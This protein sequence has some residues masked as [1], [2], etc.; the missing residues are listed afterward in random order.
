MEEFKKYVRTNIAEMMEWTPSTTMYRVSI[1]QADIENGSPKTGDMIA[2]NP[3]NHEDMWLVAADY[4]KA[5]FAKVKSTETYIDRLT[6]EKNELEEKLIKLDNVLENNLVPENAVEILTL[7]LHTMKQYLYILNQ[8]LSGEKKGHDF[9]V[10]VNKQ[11]RQELDASLQKLKNI[12]DSR[13][14]S[15]S[16]TKLQEA[17]MWLGMD[18]KR[19]NENNPYPDSYD[20]TNTKIA[21]TADNLKL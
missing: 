10:V 5:N 4:F 17:I 13:E 16:I 18:L 19:L 11:L 1:S 9:E 12:T 14:R 2:R 6:N 8:R 15:L 21:P 3:E 20:P 7:Q